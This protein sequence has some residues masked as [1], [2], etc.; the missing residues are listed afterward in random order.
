[1]ISRKEEYRN[2]VSEARNALLEIDV[3][4]LKN[5]LAVRDVRF[6]IR[7]VVCQVADDRAK[8]WAGFQGINGIDALIK[9]ADVLIPIFA[10]TRNSELGVRYD[11]EQERRSIVPLGLGNIPNNIQLRPL[12]DIAQFASEGTRERQL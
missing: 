8:P 2:V 3:L 7:V 6:A 4:P 10:A 5:R 11:D 12:H 1:V 9:D